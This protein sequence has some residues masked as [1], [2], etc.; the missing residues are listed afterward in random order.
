MRMIDAHTHVTEC[1]P[2]L[3]ALQDEFNMKFMSVCVGTVA[4]QWQQDD[5]DRY[6]KLTQ[7][8]PDR[9]AWCTAFDPPNFD[10]PDYAD[11]AIAGMKKDFADGAIGCKIWKNI[12]MEVKDPQGNFILM[13]HP[14]LEPILAFLASEAKPL[15]GHLAEPLAC[16]QPLE[17]NPHYEYYSEHPEWHMHGRTDVPNHAEILAGRDRS[18]EAHPDL[19]FIGAH[20]ASTEHDLGELARWLD[21]FPNAA[22]DCSRVYDMTFLDRDEVREFHLKYQDRV[23]LATDLCVGKPHGVPI[24]KLPEQ[25]ESIREMYRTQKAFYETDDAISIDG[26]SGRG[27][28]LPDDVLEKVYFINAEKWFPGL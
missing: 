27:I 18:L 26:H 8:M 2:E 24:D 15:M 28:A 21:R 17:G 25:I 3:L 5:A 7:E 16:W 9:F 14:I 1:G 23:M 13:D 12:G 6:R 20:M 4:G 11:K 19:V 10:D 22:V